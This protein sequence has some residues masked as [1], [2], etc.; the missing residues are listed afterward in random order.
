MPNKTILITGGTGKVGKQLIRH[1]VNKNYTV[2]F[3]SRNSEKAD[4]VINEF[5]PSQSQNSLNVIIVDLMDEQAIARVINWC[6]TH[7]LW[8]DVLINNAR[9]LDYLK[10]EGLSL[11]RTNWLNEFTL[12]VVIP[13]ELT[14]RFAHHPDSKLENVINISSMYGVVPPNPALYDDPQTQS[15]INYGICKAALI[16]LTKELA[17]R[18][19]PTIR[20]NAISYGGIEGRVDDQF[21]KRY[22][23]L[24][25]MGRMLKETEVVGAVDFLVSDHSIGMTG[26]NLVVDGGWSVW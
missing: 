20:V 18:L 14:W 24:C 7:D 26:H 22:S 10:I 2:I 19:A 4:L 13:Y 1:F 17:I 8:P 3:T 16:H 5:S 23:K 25:P 12:D 6:E 11:S 15:P 9:N 21:K